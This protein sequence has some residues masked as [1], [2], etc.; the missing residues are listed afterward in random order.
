MIDQRLQKIREEEIQEKLDGLPTPLL[1]KIDEF[2]PNAE[3]IISYEKA[4]LTSS[5]NN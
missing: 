4:E 3:F 5:K 1:T 2:I